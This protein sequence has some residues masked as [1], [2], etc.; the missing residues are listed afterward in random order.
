MFSSTPAGAAPPPRRRHALGMPAGSIRA[1]LALGILGLLWLLVFVSPEQKLPQTFIYL[2]M[3]MLLA[4]A[5]FFTAHGRTIKGASEERSPLGLPGGTIRLLILVGYGGQAYYLWH[6]QREFDLPAQGPFLLLLALLGT[7]FL[8]GHVWSWLI[9]GLSGGQRPPW[10]ADIE[11]WLALLALIC[12][13]IAAF[14]HLINPT[15]PDYLR[16]DGLYLMVIMSAIVGFYF[17]A[18]S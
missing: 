11:A 12:M 16:S 7:M 15:L 10:M 18:R 5:H 1:L 4:I 2:Q 17:G 9:L 14:I 13:V 6:H 8:L 3:L